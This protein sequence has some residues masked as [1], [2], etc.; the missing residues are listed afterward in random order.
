MAQE[1]TSILNQE[2]TKKV[3]NFYERFPYPNYP[4]FARPYCPDAYWSSSRVLGVL[5]SDLTG[6]PCGV[7][8]QLPQA[9][10]HH[11]ILVLGCGDT[12]PYL[13]KKWEPLNH[14]INFVDL[15]GKSLFRARLRFGI[16]ARKVDWVH[17]DL[18]SFLSAA[19]ETRRKFNHIDAY[20]VLHHLAEPSVALKLIAKSLAPAGTLRIMVY[21]QKARDWIR[22]IQKIF[23]LCKLKSNNREDRLLAKRLLQQMTKLPS[24]ER[25]FQGLGPQIFANE[26]R[27]CDTFFNE[28]EVSWLPNKWIETLKNIGLVPISLLDR[29]GELDDLENPLWNFPSEDQLK[30]RYLDKRFE[31]NLEI[32][33]INPNNTKTDSIVPRSRFNNIRT[34]GVPE[35][36]FDYLETKNTSIETKKL[37]WKNFISRLEQPNE[38]LQLPIEKTDHT[39]LQ[40]LARLGAIFP[41]NAKKM[42]VFDLL[43]KPICEVMEAPSKLT[44]ENLHPKLYKEIKNILRIKNIHDNRFLALITHRILRINQ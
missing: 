33:A 34:K 38:T 32:L 16:H 24:L 40:R 15:S 39:C 9:L 3:A 42:G 4:L 13:F 10:E 6:Y 17:S 29:Y 21:N 7:L 12:Q 27:L 1:F 23:K 37:L 28:R 14:H 36:W 31:N 2:I 11:Q 5:A 22:E 43:M 44:T 26:H 18:G 41:Q 35:K 30:I 20:G 8:T 19:A 25:Y